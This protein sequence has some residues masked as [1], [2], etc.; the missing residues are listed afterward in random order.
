M[1]TND[2]AFGWLRGAVARWRYRSVRS[3]AL[4]CWSFVNSRTST[5]R[6]RCSLSS[7]RHGRSPAGRPGVGTVARARSP[8]PVARAPR[9]GTRP[10]RRGASELAPS[11]S[12]PRRVLKSHRSSSTPIRSHR[13]ERDVLVPSR[14]VGPPP[15]SPGRAV[16]VA[17]HRARL[18]KGGVRRVPVSSRS[19]LVARLSVSTM[20]NRSTTRWRIS[21]ELAHRSRYEHSEEDCAPSSTRLGWMPRC[22]CWWLVT[23]RS[24][25]DPV[26]RCL[27]PP[28]LS[29]RAPVARLALGGTRTPNLLIRKMG[30]SAV[31][32][33]EDAGRRQ[34]TRRQSDAVVRGPRG[35]S[36]RPK[37]V[38]MPTALLI[39]AAAMRPKTPDMCRYNS[40]S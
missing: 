10:A 11:S 18:C 8:W 34:T 15:R 7:R 5:C 3:T 16:P 12:R 25:D 36:S 26:E 4:R 21:T 33:A 23:T 31:Q 39:P 20:R 19:E 24:F 17:A 35:I 40:S 13:T 29:A 1:S 6:P 14:G 30:V 22:R 32:T 28:A 37:P 38:R 9:L 27:P 2:E